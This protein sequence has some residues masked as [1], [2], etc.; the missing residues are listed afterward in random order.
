MSETVAVIQ[1]VHLF[2]DPLW[3]GSGFGLRDDNM[4][5]FRIG[6]VALADLVHIQG[7]F[8]ELS[9]FSGRVDGESPADADSGAGESVP[10]AAKSFAI[11]LAVSSAPDHCGADHPWVHA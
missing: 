11:V 5:T 2:L 3:K 1:L 7:Y 6:V 9:A 10:V 8:V 4:A